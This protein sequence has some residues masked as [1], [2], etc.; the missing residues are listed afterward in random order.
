NTRYW[1]I[2]AYY[3]DDDDYNSAVTPNEPVNSLNMGDE[4]LDT[5]LAT[6]SDEFINSIK[7]NQ[8]HFNA[9][10]D[11]VESMLNRDSSIISSSSKINSL[12]DEFAGELTRR[13]SIPPG[14][15][16]TDYH[17]E[18]EIRLSQRL[19]D[20]LIREELL[21]NYSHPLPE[22]ESFHFDIPLSS[23][24]PAKPP[25]GNTGILNIKMMGDVSDQKV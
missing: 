9:E 1:K 25:N 13:K 6:E 4:H 2:P 16:K 3:D 10:S 8:H 7:K 5:I 18:N 12:L 22:N 19:L 24:P 14:I 23:R 17:P 11:L 15:D 21:E 20:T